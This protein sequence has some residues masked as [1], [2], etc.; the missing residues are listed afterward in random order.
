MDALGTWLAEYR[1]EID[2]AGISNKELLQLVQ[3][4]V[5][6]KLTPTKLGI[7]VRKSGLY[8]QDRDSQGERRVYPGKA[9][10]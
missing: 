9:V 8:I 6:P 5:D 3:E 4:D 7:S 10:E 1:E 2:E